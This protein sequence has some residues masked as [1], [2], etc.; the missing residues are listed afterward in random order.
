[1]EDHVPA[2]QGHNNPPS[3]IDEIS[4]GYEAE[5]EEDPADRDERDHEGD[6][7]HEVLFHGCEVRPK[8]T[9]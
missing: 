9:F 6:P 3:P 1:M 5:R 7:C 4:A 8:L 2:P